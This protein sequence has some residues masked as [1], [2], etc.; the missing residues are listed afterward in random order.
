M[1]TM[2]MRQALIARW[3]AAGQPASM[4]ISRVEFE[5]LEEELEPWES[6]ARRD[7]PDPNLLLPLPDAPIT[8]WPALFYLDS[9]PTK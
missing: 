8:R 3:H 6:W 1:L 4:L 2:S 5:T 7:A 9:A